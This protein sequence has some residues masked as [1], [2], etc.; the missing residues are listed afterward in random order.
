MCIKCIDQLAVVPK[1]PG[2]PPG[3][4]KLQLLKHTYDR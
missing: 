2:S 3:W 4:G 1:A